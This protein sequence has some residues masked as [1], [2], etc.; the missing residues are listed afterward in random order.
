MRH[1]KALIWASL[2]LAGLAAAAGVST[3]H[4]AASAASATVE[5]RSGQNTQA[6][7]PQREV[8]RRSGASGKFRKFGSNPVRHRSPGDRQNKRRRWARRTGR[9]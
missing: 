3:P 1:T 2:A 8:Q 4:L 7:A 5:T 6:V 9:H